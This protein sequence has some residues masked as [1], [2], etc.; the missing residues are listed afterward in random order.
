M[1]TREKLGR[2]PYYRGIVAALEQD[3][4]EGRLVAG[5]RLPTQRELANTL[6]V[7][8]GTVTRAFTEAER[9]GLIA[10]RVGRGSYVLDFPEH[11]EAG[12]AGAAAAMVDLSVNTLAVEP[13]N[14]AFNRV[15]GA[16]SRRKSLHRLLEHHPI[17]GLE[18]HRAAGARWLERRGLV[19][20]TDRITVCNGAQEAL[21]AT[22]T[23]ITRSGD[24]I[25]TE[26]LNYAGIKRLANLFHLDVRGVETDAEGL[27]PD[28][29]E[30]A[31]QATEVAA[32]LCSPTVHNPTNS[33]MSEER[34][35]HILRIAKR[36]GAYVIEDDSY[37]HLS[38]STIP[39]LAALD[40]DACI[41]L[42]G[43][44][45]SIAPGLRIGFMAAPAAVIPRLHE[46][47]HATSWTSPSLMG[48]VAATLIED[49]TA[50]R[51]LA[52]HRAEA[53]ARLAAACEVFGLPSL[54]PG[55]PTFHVWLHLPA[56]WRADDFAL[57]AKRE[58]VLVS[59]AGDFAVDR[60]PAP[61]AVRISLGSVVDRGELVRALRLVKACLGARPG[62]S[63]SLA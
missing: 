58:G 34:R 33:V 18:R 26:S 60:S 31:A 19:V 27:C 61:H 25:L 21:L 46:G 15:F 12:E 47:I 52:R 57:E 53:T 45:K 43:T 24:T 51:F 50:D 9:R 41:Y 62:I 13:F 36:I 39:P 40:P 56:P 7:T 28:R 6:G 44:S 14:Q 2:R 1:W 11:L 38:G 37:G 20:P 35:R 63:R 48:E 32:I 3:I 29:L 17:P 16:L 49:G 55:V 42:C 5:Q 59:P 8:V 4:A 10:S 30:E 22:L 23:S 54:S